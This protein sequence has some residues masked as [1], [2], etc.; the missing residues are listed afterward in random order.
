MG[1]DRIRRLLRWLR[2]SISLAPHAKKVFSGSQLVK[3][4][5][6]TCG[7]DCYGIK[8]E[9]HPMCARCFFEKI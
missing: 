5:C 7:E 1:S 3:M 6:E 9:P 2:G 8:D 4:R